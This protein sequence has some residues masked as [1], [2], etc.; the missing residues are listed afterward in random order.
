[1]FGQVV[2]MVCAGV[3]WEGI[4]C[5]APQHVPTPRAAVVTDQRHLAATLIEPIL[6]DFVAVC[7]AKPVLIDL[8]DSL[9]TCPLILIDFNK[10][11]CMC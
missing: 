4:D 11:L 5:V 1:M 7:L 2:V 9:A 6:I 3:W 8:D 10:R